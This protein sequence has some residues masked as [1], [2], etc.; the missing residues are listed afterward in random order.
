MNED[1]LIY[2]KE[3]FQGNWFYLHSELKN[4]YLNIVFYKHW[5]RN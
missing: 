2:K 1:R 3:E 4:Q 5:H